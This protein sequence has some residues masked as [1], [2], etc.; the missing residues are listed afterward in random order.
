M[1]L[2]SLEKSQSLTCVCCT[3]I[4]TKLVF[5]ECKFLPREK[6]VK[7]KK[8]K[9]ATKK[10]RKQVKK[11]E[12]EKRDKAKQKKEEG[13]HPSN[14]TCLASVGWSINPA[15]NLRKIERYTKNIKTSSDKKRKDKKAIDKKERKQKPEIKRGL[16]KLRFD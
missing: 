2:I 1:Y 8:A 10:R 5:P 9:R 11:K 7:E 4:S 6:R 3:K 16:W 14:T 13:T 12:S 15:K